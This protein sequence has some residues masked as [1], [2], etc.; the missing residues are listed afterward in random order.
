MTTSVTKLL[1]LAKAT[2]YEHFPQGVMVFRKSSGKWHA[3]IIT[4]DTET[5]SSIVA[6]EESGSA[7]SAIMDL[8]ER[9]T[10][11]AKQ[12]LDSARR[13]VEKYEKAIGGSK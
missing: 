13:E 12:K 6:H 9:I 11:S 4:K 8:E 7:D 2:G 1:E 5:P 3:A 10:A